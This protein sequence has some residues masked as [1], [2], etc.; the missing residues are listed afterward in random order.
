MCSRPDQKCRDRRFAG[1]AWLAGRIWL[2][3]LLPLGLVM[4]ARAD[5]RPATMLPPQPAISHVPAYVP[6]ASGDS[7]VS[8]NVPSPTEQQRNRDPN[9]VYPPTY[10][11]TKRDNDP[12]SISGLW[13]RI[14]KGKPA[15]SEEKQPAETDVAKTTSHRHAQRQ[16]AIQQS[17]VAAGPLPAWRWYGYGAPTPGRNIYAPDG[18]YGTVDP[19]YFN[20]NGS[21]PGAVPIVQP[22]VLPRPNSDE[23]P[24]M[25]GR[26]TLEPP[27][28]PLPDPA[29]KSNLILPPDQPLADRPADLVMPLRPVK[30]TERETPISAAPTVPVTRAQAPVVDISATLLSALRTACT[31]YVTKIELMPQGPS[32]IG[33]RLTLVQGVFA[34]RIADR[35]AKLPDLAGYAIE[36]EFAR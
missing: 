35:I 8:G 28:V 10:K 15:A 21:T 32:Q 17:P 13:N 33:L 27:V 36:M 29:Q 11:E 22:H 9:F 5:E 4:S 31:G 24:M 30:S 7:F 6:R 34:D 25:S 14:I 23:P 1:R 12:T 2:A 3:T 16:P 20:Q 18:V 19:N 26:P